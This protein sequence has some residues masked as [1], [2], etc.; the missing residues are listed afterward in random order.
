MYAD[1]VEKDGEF[2]IVFP[3]GST[4]ADWNVGDTVEWIDNQDGSWTLRKKTMDFV[5]QVVEFNEVAGTGASFDTR[6]VA[7][8][9]GLQLEEM[10]EKIEALA[11]YPE[12]KHSIDLLKYTLER[13]SKSFKEGLYDKN[14]EGIDRIEALDADIDLAVVALGGACAMGA[15]VKAAANEVMRSNLA[16]FPI[17]D[18][19]KRYA[20]KDAN[21]KVVK[22]SYWTPPNLEGMV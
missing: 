1:V 2:Y 10:A 14:V 13:Y 17:D 6:K 3:E 4:P 19:G 21:G 18:N 22:P 20:V 8:Y 15:K 7:L 11:E 12:S 9:I 5:E 16:K